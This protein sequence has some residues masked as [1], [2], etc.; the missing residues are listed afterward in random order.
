LYILGL[1]DCVLTAFKLVVSVSYNGKCCGMCD[2]F[3]VLHQM[4]GLGLEHGAE[5]D[6]TALELSTFSL[7]WSL[8]GALY[9][10]LQCS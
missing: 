7:N 5:C 10:C 1:E 9:R 8:T 3:S 4:I 6:K 2:C